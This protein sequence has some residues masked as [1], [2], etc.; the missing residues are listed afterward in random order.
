M[1][2]GFSIF[3]LYVAPLIA[4][5]AWLISLIRIRSWRL[6]GMTIFVIMLIVATSS[7]AIF[8]VTLNP[9]LM[10]IL[11]GLALFNTLVLPRMEASARPYLIQANFV[12]L[13]M[14]AGLHLWAT[15]V[16]QS[17]LYFYEQSDYWTT[18]FPLLLTT[19]SLAIPMTAILIKF[20]PDNGRFWSMIM[21]VGLIVL[22]LGFGFILA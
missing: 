20:K 16:R 9:Y 4:V 13:L 5:I 19:L 7:N 6:V 18:T 10:L 15:F 1:S 11:L 3:S 21:I 2:I 14:I 12:L 22:S 8:A 17:D